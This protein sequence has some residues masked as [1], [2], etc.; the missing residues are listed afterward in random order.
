MVLA[1]TIV[2]AGNEIRTRLLG[3]GLMVGG[4]VIILL[5]AKR[6]GIS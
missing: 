2:C 4:A 1:G 3:S 5:F 6:G